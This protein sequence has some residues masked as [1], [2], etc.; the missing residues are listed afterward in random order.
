M[1][2]DWSFVL[3]FAAGFTL[4]L[5]V[6]LVRRDRE[7]R[8]N[9]DDYKFGNELT[10]A[11]KTS[12]HQPMSAVE[13]SVRVHGHQEY[14]QLVLEP[15]GVNYAKK[16]PEEMQAL[17]YDA[18]A[19]AQ[20]YLHIAAEHENFNKPKPAADPHTFQGLLAKAE[21]YKG[22]TIAQKK[23]LTDIA[24]WQHQVMAYVLQTHP[25]DDWLVDTVKSLKKVLADWATPS[26]SSGAYGIVNFLRQHFNGMDERVPYCP[27]ADDPHCEC[28]GMYNS[29]SLHNMVIH[30]NDDH[31]WSR[32]NI[33]DW[34]ETL[35]IDTTEKEHVA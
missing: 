33:A 16:T 13:V 34:I 31:K 35:D 26:P 5:M 14:V 21:H 24:K 1:S 7:K 32:E 10:D 30:L 28:D 20:K 12:L 18:V 2:I 25:T 4:T 11:W 17:L 29:V 8:M 9:Y 23:V 19:T 27:A 22:K 15:P 6:W 3:S